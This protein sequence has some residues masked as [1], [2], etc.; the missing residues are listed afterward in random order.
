MSKELLNEFWVVEMEQASKFAKELQVKDEDIKFLDLRVKS[1]LNLALKKNIE[2]ELDRNFG[3]LYT[4]LD[5]VV[6]NLEKNSQKYLLNRLI[7]IK[8]IY[9]SC[10]LSSISVMDTNRMK[11][12]RYIEQLL[13]LITNY[14]FNEF[15][16]ILEY[17]IG[18]E[19]S[20]NSNLFEYIWGIEKKSRF[21]NNAESTLTSKALISLLALNSQR[22]YHH[23]IKDFKK[24]IKFTKQDN[25]DVI[26]YLS[27]YKVKNKQGCYLA[28]N[29]IL[30]GI[31]H[32]DSFEL[33]SEIIIWLDNASG[34]SPKKAWLDK[35]ASIENK[36]EKVDLL[37]ITNWIISNKHLERERSTGWL[38]DVFKR[39]Q[40]SAKWYLDGIS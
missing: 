15:I 32:E 35:L 40:K 8:D 2:N 9:Q 3:T 4:L 13:S 22:G 7:K 16:A 17:M 25:S 36:I 27:K 37:N 34:S 21:F 28:I 24:I 12:S 30:T 14:C 31:E 6:V 20:P 33:K 29:N 38:D 18:T 11:I 39:F 19:V 23:N 26:E 5:N 10:K 1:W